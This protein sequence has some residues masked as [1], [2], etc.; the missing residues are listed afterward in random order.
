[1]IDNKFRKLK[2]VWL[3]DSGS[4]LSLADHDG[5]ETIL[6]EDRLKM[7]DWMQDVNDFDEQSQVE[8]EQTLIDIGW[9][10]EEY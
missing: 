1:M 6:N 8:I 4:K 9:V 3:K 5:L 7:S 2:T 10:E